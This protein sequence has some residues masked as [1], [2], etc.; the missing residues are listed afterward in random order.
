MEY[1]FT[2]NINIRSDFRGY[3]IL[4]DFYNKTKDLGFEEVILN[5]ENVEWFDANLS[6]AF[7]AILNDISSRLND[8]KLINISSDIE[9][10][11]QR[12][13][14]LS[15][16]GS[17]TIIEDNY[18]TTSK[19]KKFKITEEKSFKDY[20][21]IELLS[22]KTMP[23]M[24]EKLRKKINES[25]FEIFNNAVIHGKCKEIFS[26]GQ[27]YKKKNKLDFTI[28]DIGA[29]IKENVTNY[30]NGSS[31]GQNSIAWAVIEGHTTK[32]GD[33][34]GGLG[35]SLIR[36]FLEKN[37][38]KIQ[39]ISANEYWEQNAEKCIEGNFSQKF[40][41]TIVNLEFNIGDKGYYSLASEKINSDEIF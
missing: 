6:A 26:C 17:H 37:K 20:L 10:I 2:G 12:N 35:L 24:S 11:W 34:P 1:K 36:E 18:D 31:Y 29:T 5:F 32:T 27:Y 38:G 7:G 23:E 19:Y 40:P 8:I 30:L 4:I 33:I 16:F 41:G 22:K 3:E 21:N 15:N 13:H 28:V 25:I 39:I 9:K 14:F